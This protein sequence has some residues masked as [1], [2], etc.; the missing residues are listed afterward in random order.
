[1]ELQQTD[2][3]PSSGTA[4]AD[5]ACFTAE[6]SRIVTRL[7]TEPRTPAGAI[8]VREP[9]LD[10]NAPNCSDLDVI[11]FAEV[12]ELLPQRLILPGYPQHAPLV[13][14]IWLPAKLLSRPDTL[15]VQGVIPHRILGSRVIHDRSGDAIRQIATLSDLF[16]RPDIQTARIQGLLQLG[17]DAVREVGVTRDFPGLA[18]FW[19]HMAAASL[20][21]ALADG[22]NLLCPNVYTRP[23]DHVPGISDAWNMDLNLELE[24]ALVDML[25]LDQRIEPMI[26]RLRQIHGEVARAFPEPQWPDNMRQ[27]TRYEYRYFS[28]ADELDWRIRVARELA[29][30]GKPWAAV[31]S[32]RFWA[33]MLACVPMVYHRAKASLDVS[34]VRPQRAVRPDLELNC[35]RIIDKLEF[36]FGESGGVD[37][38]AVDTAVR[39]MQR[40]RDETLA[41][42]AGRGLDLNGTAHWQP[43][44]ADT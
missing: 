28:S 17:A 30:N 18:L 29:H 14:L 26:T 11:A 43:F 22:A 39:R 9:L 6:L 44:R 31:F 42:L 33:Y 13:D 25:H 1:M 41:L 27:C 15:A 8:L 34:F 21:S 2:V 3:Y 10:P 23:F 24:P 4:A 38:H 7:I 12:D 19:L 20:L 37:M 32:L 35:P 16:N 5:S 40:L 36:I